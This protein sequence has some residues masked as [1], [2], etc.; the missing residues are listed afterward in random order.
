[1]KSW[2]SF[3]VPYIEAN[4][5]IPP[6]PIARVEVSVDFKVYRPARPKNMRNAIR[7]WNVNALNE[8]SAPR[9]PTPSIPSSPS[10]ISAATP[11]IIIN[12]N[13]SRK[14][15]PPTKAEAANSNSSPVAS[16]KPN[17]SKMSKS[18]SMLIDLPTW[19]SPLYPFGEGKTKNRSIPG[20]SL[21]EVTFYSQYW[22][23]R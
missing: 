19:A 16:P 8:A 3:P 17:S 6:T 21:C 20:L 4:P 5:A 10:K 12:A 14:S 9:S 2:N 1:M 13:Q 7:P 15:I 18:S 23:H 11:P 22:P